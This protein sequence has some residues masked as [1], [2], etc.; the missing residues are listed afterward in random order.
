MKNNIYTLLKASDYKFKKE[1]YISDLEIQLKYFS[2]F[3][4]TNNF[5]INI[6]T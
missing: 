4:K 6:Q 5:I 1:I 2:I 3:Y